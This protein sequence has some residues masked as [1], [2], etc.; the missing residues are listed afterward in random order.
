[1]LKLRRALECH[2]CARRFVRIA[3]RLP[4]SVS[5]VALGK[6]LALREDR[7][8]PPACRR[9]LALCSA[10]AQDQRDSPRL[11]CSLCPPNKS[12]QEKDRRDRDTSL[13]FSAGRLALAALQ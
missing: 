5:Q 11:N 13:R 3:I 4:L 2:P 9:P 8:R 10:T 7:F 6:R 12:H 1:M